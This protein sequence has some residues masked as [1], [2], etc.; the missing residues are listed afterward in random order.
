M[1]PPVERISKTTG[2]LMIGTAI[3]FDV[4]GL[5]PLINI[6]PAIANFVLFPIW[7]YTRGVTYTKNKSVLWWTAVTSVIGLVPFLSSV[8]PE[9]TTGVVRNVLHVRKQDK[10]AVKDYE[11]YVDQKRRADYNEQVQQTQVQQATEQQSRSGVVAGGGGFDKRPNSTSRS[12]GVRRA[13]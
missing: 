12:D 9:L 10:K 11:N 2:W 1:N 8:L 6:A 4:I 3:L 13:A 5:I 7:F